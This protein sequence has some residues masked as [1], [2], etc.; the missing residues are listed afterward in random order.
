MEKSN[1]YWCLTQKD[2]MDLNA[3]GHYIYFADTVCD[4]EDACLMNERAPRLGHDVILEPYYAD[5]C[6]TAFKVVGLTNEYAE[7]NFSYDFIYLLT[8]EEVQAMK[9]KNNDA[10]KK[11]DAD[12]TAAYL[13]CLEPDEIYEL[14]VKA[15]KIETYSDYTMRRYIVDALTKDKL[16]YMSTLLE[17][18]REE[19]FS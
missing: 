2:M 14:L 5:G 11:I 1:L 9:A 19:L 18:V 16:V 4:I 17:K 13:S 3:A 15:G 10:F 7:I 8:T 6:P 12:N